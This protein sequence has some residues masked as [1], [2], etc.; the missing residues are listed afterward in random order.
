MKPRLMKASCHSLSA[1]VELKDIYN[2]RGR[3]LAFS[4]E[5]NDGEMGEQEEGELTFL[6]FAC[7][8]GRGGGRAFSRSAVTTEKRPKKREKNGE[9]GLFS[10]TTAK[11]TKGFK[12]SMKP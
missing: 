1:F 6:C 11:P 7:L 2:I 5:V 4:S 3:L 10:V 9:L 8:M 12:G